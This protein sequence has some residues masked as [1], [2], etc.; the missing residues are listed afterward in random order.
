MRAIDRIGRRCRS[1]RGRA[2]IGAGGLGFAAGVLALAAPAASEV[3]LGR[4]GAGDF[5][6]SVMSWWEIPFRSI[7]RQ[8]HDFSCGSAAVATLLTYHYGRPTP[9]RESFAAMWRGGDQERIRKTGFSMFEMKTFLDGLGYRAAGVRLT[10]DQLRSLTRPIIVLIDLNGFKHFVVVKGVSGER[11]LLGDP[12]LGL[13]QYDMADFARMWNNIGLVILEAPTEDGP[14]FNL[15]SDWGPW[16][17][18]PLDA[19]NG[20]LRVA[21][22]D[23]TTHLPPSYQLTPQMLLDVRVGTVR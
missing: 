12:M 4:E 16:S 10:P 7:V 1:G 5:R 15:A 11:I 2:L 6:V 22:G 9:E 3:R 19:G 18:A 23:L 20:A 17:Q 14:L 8:Q 13:T 21:S